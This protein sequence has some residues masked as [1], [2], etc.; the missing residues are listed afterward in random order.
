M[1]TI[2]TGVY[3]IRNN[4]TGRC[5]YGSTKVHF[6][7]RFD[8]HIKDLNNNVHDNIELQDDW[9]KY[10]GKW[11]IFKVLHRITDGDTMLAVEN[12]YKAKEREKITIPL[13]RKNAGYLNIN[14]LM[15]S[16]KERYKEGTHY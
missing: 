15:G 11:F 9:N 13:P 5:W 7:P 6:K 12:S 2:N 8:M 14:S 4:K 3:R 1:S 10:G 16:L